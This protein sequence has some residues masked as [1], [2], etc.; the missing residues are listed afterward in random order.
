MDTH[1]PRTT[2]DYRILHNLDARFTRPYQHGDRL[3]DGYAGCMTA[4]DLKAVPGEVFATHN[5]DDRPDGR[6]APS[7]SVG[8]VIIIGETAVSVDRF[9][10]VAVSLDTADLLGVPW[11]EARS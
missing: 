10:F 7:L 1:S 5:R 6:S 3:A 11:L 9:G 4:A 2:V 8:D